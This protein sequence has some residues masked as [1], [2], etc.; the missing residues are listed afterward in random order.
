VIIFEKISWRNFLSTGNQPTTI[1][2]NQSQST[3]IVGTNGAGKS[4][5][6]DALTFVLYG[7]SFRKV[8]KDQLINT[9]NE[10]GTLVEIEFN[11]NRVDWKIE[12]GIKP[13]IFKVYRNGEE[14]D[15]RSTEVV[16][17]ECSEDEL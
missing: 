10:K 7:K 12:R 6:L 9:T 14:L 15:Q 11:V 16:G 13:N 3:M 17:T 4:T 8:K 5:I 2:L 1:Q